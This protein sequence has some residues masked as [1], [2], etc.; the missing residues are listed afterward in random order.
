MSMLHDTLFTEIAKVIAHVKK[1]AYEGDEHLP[2]AGMHV[3]LMGDIHQFL[4]T[5]RTIFIKSYK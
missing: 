4:P 1:K 5:A 3:V 2:F